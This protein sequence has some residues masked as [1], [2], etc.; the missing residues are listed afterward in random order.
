[1]MLCISGPESTGKTTLALA[2]KK[3]LSA[4]Y[5][6]E[7]AREWFDSKHSTSYQ[8]SDLLTLAMGQ[9]EREQKAREQPGFI[10]LDTDL[11]NI[12]LWSEYRYGRCHQWITEQSRQVADKFY[13]LMADDI[14]WVPDPLREDPDRSGL[15]ISW[16]RVFA[17]YGARYALVTGHG[18]KRTRRALELIALH[19]GSTIVSS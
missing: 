7:Y 6:S 11:I 4:Y 13:L 15:L 16:K 9:W 14:P 18:H 3:Y 8:E 12:K 2:L 17:E 1:M 10:V 5:V 19:A